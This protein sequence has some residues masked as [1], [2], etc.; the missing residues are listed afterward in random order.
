M[1][2]LTLAAG[3]G[4]RA[5]EGEYT[6]KALIKVRE[7]PLIYWSMDSFH[8]LRTCGILSNDK[9]FVV[10]RKSDL[11]TFNFVEQVQEQLTSN[12]RITEV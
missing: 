7:K 9:L 5:Q 11:D 10:V 1:I 6:P 8:S 3:L 2:L 12:V 4:T